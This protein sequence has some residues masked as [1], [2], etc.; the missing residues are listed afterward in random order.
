MKSLIVL[1]WLGVVA[2]G[3]GF[4]ALP[5]AHAQPGCNT[6]YNQHG[7]TDGQVCGYGGCDDGVPTDDCETDYCSNGCTDGQAE[8]CIGDQYCGDYS[9]CYFWECA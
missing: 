3:T 2:F 6:S 1:L 4:L 5:S 9:G 7:A 8:Y